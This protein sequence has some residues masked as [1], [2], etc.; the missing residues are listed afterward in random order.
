[1][2]KLL[3]ILL[4][5]TMV[6]ALAACGA[7][8][9]D[10]S[11]TTEP[12]SEDVVTEAPTDEVTEPTE[13]ESTT[14]A[15]DESKEDATDE[16]KEDASKEESKKE[17]E[18]SKEEEK[19][20]FNSTDAKEVVEFY[21]AARKATNPAPKGH[22]TMALSGEITGDGFIGAL[23]QVLQPAAKSAL[24]KNSKDT[25][26]IPGHDHDDIL[27]SDVKSAKATTKNGVTTV[28]MTFKDQVDGPDSSKGPVERGISTLGSIDS[29]LSEL[30]A[31]ITEGRD[32][33]KLT[34]TDAYLKATIKDGKI[35]GGTWHYLVKIFVGNAKGKLGISITLKNLKA[36]VDYK[37]V[38]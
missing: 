31:E 24:E 20:E 21:N 37:V 5:L 27:P 32:T 8:T 1:M 4:A 2:K 30:G 28:E 33:V 12:T 15:P 19:K 3:A 9:E 6:I 13:D 38:I 25:D 35:T 11:T 22:Q 34:Y 17:E 7:K 26:W 10:E 18:E 16:S 14:E 36:A 23:L 29:A